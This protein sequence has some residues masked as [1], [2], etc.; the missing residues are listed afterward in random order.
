MTET[1]INSDTNNSQIPELLNN[2]Q[3]FKILQVPRV[4]AK[5]GG[6]GFFLRKA[7]NS[8][9]LNDFSPKSFELIDMLMRL[10]E[11]TCRV[12]LIYRPPPSR[13][14]KLTTNIFLDE[15]A[16]LIESVVN[17]RPTLMF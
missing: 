7:L 6:V 10:K 8:L 15:F 17:T 3:E 5:G 14:N 2:L 9:I 16:Q 12:I 13:K 4:S 1:W 11:F